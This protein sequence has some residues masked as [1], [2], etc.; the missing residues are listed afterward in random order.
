MD[1]KI[2]NI[3]ILAILFLLTMFVCINSIVY[4]ATSSDKQE[5]E[6]MLNQYKN[7]LGDLKQLKTVVDKIYSDVNSASSVDD[8]L[9]QTLKS[10]INML[11]N[12]SGMNSLVLMVL[13]SELTSQI[14]QLDDSNLEELKDEVQIIKKWVD[15]Q[16][17]EDSGGDDI[18]TNTTPSESDNNISDE[19]PGDTTNKITKENTDQI[20]EIGND[21][22]FTLPNTGVGKIALIIFVI[23]AIAIIVSVMKYQK[24]KD[25]K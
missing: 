21:K 8:N 16:V 9:K 17:G 12:V 15:E 24:L 22:T 20:S 25:V 13:K 14:D 10:D 23:L 19:I 6:N 3:C 18:S 11:D 5:L 1:K 7:E 2:K 4:A